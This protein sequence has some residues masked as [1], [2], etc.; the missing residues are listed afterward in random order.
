VN[1]EIAVVHQNPFGIL[2]AFHACWKLAVVGLQGLIDFVANCLVL[3]GVCAGANNEVVGKTCDVSEI[4][5]DN[6]L[7][8]FGLSCMNGTEPVRDGSISL[9]NGSSSLERLG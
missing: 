6:I 1:H 4:Q 3:A 2:M 9:G 8:F 7:R 5:D